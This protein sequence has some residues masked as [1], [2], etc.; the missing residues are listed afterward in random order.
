MYNLSL[1]VTGQAKRE[2]TIMSLDVVLYAEDVDAKNSIKILADRYNLLLKSIASLIEGKCSVSKGTVTTRAQYKTVKKTEGKS[3]VDS[4]EFSHYYS[5]QSISV[6]DMEID[7]D[8]LILLLNE[9][10]S[11]E[12][13]SSCN[14]YFSLRAN[15]LYALK[16]EAI[17]NAYNEAIR[18]AEMFSK[19]S[20]NEGKYSLSDVSMAFTPSRGSVSKSYCDDK[21]Y[22]GSS[23]KDTGLV[24]L[25]ENIGIKDVSTSESMSFVFNIG[26]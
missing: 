4:R 1:S 18:K 13:V 7:K 12:G 25:R 16:E 19:L 24:L 15:E 9:A 2:P 23:V 10:Y 14:F 26:D 21:A 3:I 17:K 20:G 6:K 8:L 11:S 5:S 22:F